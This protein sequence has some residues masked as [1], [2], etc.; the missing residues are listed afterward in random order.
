MPIFTPSL[1]AL[2]QARAQ[3]LAT[4]GKD[5]PFFLWQRMADN[6]RESLLDINRSFDH[7]AEIA[8]YALVFDDAQ[9]TKKKITQVTTITPTQIEKDI[10]PLEPFTL[11][12]LV[13]WGYLHW[14]NE[15]PEMLLQCRYAL[16]PD[17]VFVGSM[18]GGESLYELRE[19]IT[20][21]EMRQTGGI[22]PRV[23]PFAQLPDMAALLQN[24]G[25]ALPV[26]DHDIL[27]ITYPDFKTLVR[28]LRLSGQTNAITKQNKKTPPKN[29]WKDVEECY[30]DRYSE[31]GRLL[32]TVEIISLI[33]WAPDAS[34]QQPAKRGS[35]THRLA[36][37][38]KTEEK[39]SGDYI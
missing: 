35:A 18:I 6:I 30:R 31:K 33:G 25:F 15:L 7:V 29:F 36:D 9:K 16:K 14:V 3:R 19:A 38:L 20:E 10:L 27:T 22:S 21:V 34:Q 12:A 28:D 4:S 5:G 2:R 37:L 13:S 32:A 8:P 23:S 39:G 1:L 17:G 11:D 26:A 24:A